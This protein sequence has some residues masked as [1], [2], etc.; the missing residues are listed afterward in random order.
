MAKKQKSFADKASGKGAD[1]DSVMV[2]YVKSVKSEKTG[3]WRF[4][5]QMIKLRGGENLD[6]ALKRL[7][8]ALNLVDIDLSEFELKAQESEEKVS[9]NE[10]TV[11]ASDSEIQVEAA[12]ASDSVSDPDGEEE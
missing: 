5:E 11:A 8:E 3:F 10:E 9:E 2:K 4:N 12:A 1:A 6:A 7:D